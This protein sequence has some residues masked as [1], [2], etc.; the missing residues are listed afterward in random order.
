MALHFFY[1]AN[2]YQILF[3]FFC[4]QWYPENIFKETSVNQ[5][6]QNDLINYAD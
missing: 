1:C 2:E 5:I 6:N 3:E 4:F